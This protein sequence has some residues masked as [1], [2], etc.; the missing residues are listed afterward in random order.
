MSQKRKS[1]ASGAGV[2][3]KSRTIT[4]KTNVDI[5]KRCER[6]EKMINIANALGMN[7]LTVGTILKDKEHI[8]QHVKGS[9]LMHFTII[10][11][12]RGSVI[13]EMEKLLS[14][15]LEDQHQYHM[16]ISLNLIQRKALSLFLNIK[17]KHG[18]S[19]AEETF[20]A[21][22]GWF[23]RYKARSNL[24]NIQV[25]NVDETGIYWEKMPDRTYIAK[26]EK[27]MPGFK[28]SKDRLILLLGGN[29][30]G[31]C[32]LKPLLV[33]HSK[34]PKALKGVVKASLPV[35]W[36]ANPKAWMTRVLFEDWFFHNFVPDV[37]KNC[38]NKNQPFKILLVLDNAPG[39]PSYLDDFHANIKV[40]YLPPNTTSV[41][42]PMDQ[43]VMA[44]F[45]EY[46][47]RRTFT[48]AVKETEGESG[49]T[50]REFW[51]NYIYKAIKNIDASWRE[52]K[53]SNMNGVWKKLCPQFANDFKGFTENVDSVANN[54]V[55]LGKQL[56]LEM[57]EDDV[58]ELMECHTQELT[59]ENLMELESD[60]VQEEVAEE[61]QEAE[62]PKKF[63]SKQLDEDFSM[64]EKALASF[65]PQDPNIERFTKVC[66]AVHNAIACYKIIY[67]EKKR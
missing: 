18:E 16:P 33:Y 49:V 2:S 65:E 5:I 9:V 46:Y 43:G 57:E 23:H 3:K 26:E 14:V 56:H 13:A 36:K 59:N 55:E 30:A 54:L 35:V 22:H 20:T 39:H 15:W 37:E 27:T 53:T 10:S 34:N 58:H 50:L 44:S 45:K 19:V 6:G 4:L 41:L 38:N 31:D 28:A 8:M 21:G 62:E 52:V 47:L 11:K 66:A 29:A 51:K 32:K 48:Q 64:I 40:V 61:E 60:R 67:E 25:F 12:K 1:D 17:A 24:R 63:N 7:R 42:Q